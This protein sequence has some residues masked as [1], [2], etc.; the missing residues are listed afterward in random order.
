MYEGASGERFTIYCRRTQAP[1]SALRYRAAGMVG[2]FFW[3]EAA[4]GFVVSG[5]PDRARLQ[6]IAEAA[7]GQLEGRGKTGALRQELA[8][9]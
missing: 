8:G 7:Y 2:T 5:P 1:E 9:R 3:V 4:V 6:T